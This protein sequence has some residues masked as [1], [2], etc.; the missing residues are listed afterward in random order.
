MEEYLLLILGHM[1]PQIH[2]I[3]KLYTVEEAKSHKNIEKPHI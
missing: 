3:Y 1:N 2:K